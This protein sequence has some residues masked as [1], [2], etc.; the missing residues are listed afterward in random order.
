MPTHFE[1]LCSVIDT[2]PADLDFELSQQSE[3]QFPEISG[4]SQ[5]LEGHHLLQQSNAD[6]ASSQA[7]LIH[8]IL[9]RILLYLKE[10]NGEHSKSPRKGGLQ[11]ST[12]EPTP[13]S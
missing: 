9:P 11:N 10:P 5:E 6:S 4:L 12:T 7:W 2:L 1:R 3:L 8:Q 13:R